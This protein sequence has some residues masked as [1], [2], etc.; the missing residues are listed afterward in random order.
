MTSP[1]DQNLWITHAPTT[2]G[3]EGHTHSHGAYGT[4]DS[5][6]NGMHYGTH[7]HEA[8]NEH[9]HEAQHPHPKDAP[10]RT[11]QPGSGEHL[12]VGNTSGGQMTDKLGPAER[13]RLQNAQLAT[14]EAG[15]GEPR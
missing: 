5:D 13:R 11:R 4:S 3:P 15:R 10:G 9:D 1:S 12:T 7:T 2:T 6:P 8:D 14:H